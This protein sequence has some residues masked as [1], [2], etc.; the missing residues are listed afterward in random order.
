[1]NEVWSPY[2]NYQIQCLVNVQNRFLRFMAFKYNIIRV[3]HSPYQSLLH[4]FDI[5]SL[6]EGR[7]IYDIKFLFKLV[8]GFINNPEILGYFNFNV[9]QY[10]TRSTTM[11]YVCIHKTNYV[12]SFPINRIMIISN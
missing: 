7:E 4:F 11:F 1:V 3:P 10:R 8:N 6:S 12:S 5:T 2:V 9:P